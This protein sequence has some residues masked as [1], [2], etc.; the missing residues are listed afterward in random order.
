M[1][2]T[3]INVH[4]LTLS[5]LHLRRSA[6]AAGGW[7]ANIYDARFDRW[8][9]LINR[10]ERE[11]CNTSSL[12]RSNIRTCSPRFNELIDRIELVAGRSTAPILLLGPTG[13]GKSQL[14][15]RIYEMRRRM[16]FVQGRF[17]EYNCAVLDRE[18]AM[19]TLFGHVRG[20][21]TGSVASRPGLLK[22]ADNG[23]LFLDEVGELNP[24]VQVTLLKALEEKRYYPF[25]SDTEVTSSFQ[26]ICATN[27]DLERLSRTG[28]FRQ[29]LLERIN[30]WSFEL[31]ALRDRPEDIEPNLEYEL[32]RLRRETGRHI[33]F[34]PD[35]RRLFLDFAV[36][37]EGLWPGNFRTFSAAVQR[38]A[39]FAVNGGID[40][41][42]VAREVD[43]LRQ[44]WSADR[45]DSAQSAP[46][47]AERFPLQRRL[48]AAGLIAPVE[49]CDLF[50][51]VQ[52]EEVLAVCAAASSRSEAGQKLFAVSRLARGRQD[53]TS[54]LNKYLK[55]RG[56][57]WTMLGC[58]RGPAPLPV[59]ETRTG[60]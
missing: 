40:S 23:I 53:D 10:H 32:E 25:G 38:M 45:E 9:S 7:R 56:L 14:A 12:L 47:A 54:R 49:E 29:D 11:Y 18:M 55:S 28:A 31:P 51:A 36:S 8:L 59:P 19:S 4:N 48:E 20:S 35:A 60:A 42:V 16:G 21:F 39:T 37:G 50:D 24:D 43:M 6:D 27:R 2:T 13:S 46:H 58:L 5:V 52:L 34:T 3:L 1:I 33:D 57:S 30:L 26:L 17:V 15:R 22:A 44:R 41:S